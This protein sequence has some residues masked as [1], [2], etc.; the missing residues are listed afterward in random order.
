M[1]LKDKNLLSVNDVVFM[2]VVSIVSLRQI[3]NVT[4][5]GASSIFLWIIFVLCFFLLF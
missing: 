2:N 1:N 5:Y 3:P 4:T